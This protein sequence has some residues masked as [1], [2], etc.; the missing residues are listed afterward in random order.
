[1]GG[2]KEPLKRHP[3]IPENSPKNPLLV[4]IL[5]GW[6]WA[7][8]DEFNAISRAETPFM[9]SLEKNAPD[10]WRLVS[11]HGKWVGL[12][13]TDMGNSEVNSSLLHFLFSD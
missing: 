13:E 1:M 4:L 6:G 12:N 5:D 11:A 7:K 8:E 10:R 2:K 9:D 3:V